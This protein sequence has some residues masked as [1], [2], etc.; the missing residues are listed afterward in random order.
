MTQ[1][2]RATILSWPFE[3]SYFGLN[4]VY[5]I[6]SIYKV[7]CTFTQQLRNWKK[8]RVNFLYY[9]GQQGFFINAKTMQ[10]RV[11]KCVITEIPQVKVILTDN[12][13]TSFELELKEVV[14][15]FQFL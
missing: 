12:K 14:V 9:D 15:V 4:I 7:I 11:N 1:N 6:F 8:N 10:V 3:I 2:T 13:Y 5:S